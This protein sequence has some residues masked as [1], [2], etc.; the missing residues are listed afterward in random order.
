MKTTLALLLTA[1]VSTSVLAAPS[2]DLTVR[3]DDGSSTIVV[4]PGETINFEIHG[5]LSS[6]TDNEGLAL[7]GLDLTN[8]GGPLDGS[9]VINPTADPIMQNF[10]RN[11]GITNPDSPCPPACGFSGT[12]INDDLVQVGGGQNTINNTAANAPFPIGGVI[13]NVAHP[14][15]GQILAEGTITAPAGVGVYTLSIPVSSVF[16]N[17]ISPGQGCAPNPA[18]PTT[19][20]SAEAATVG[21]IINL[22]Y[23]VEDPVCT[24]AS[25]TVWES[26]GTHLRGVGDVALAITAPN[27]DGTSSF[28]EPRGSGLS[29]IRVS[30]TPGTTIDAGSAVAGNVAV[31]G[32]DVGGNPVDL[33][34]VV[35]GVSSVAS[36]TQLEITFTPALPDFATY[37]VALPGITTCGGAISG[38]VSGCATALQ[39]DLSG[40]VRVRAN[41]VAGARGYVGIDPIDPV[42][43]I[44]QA[45]SDISLDG[46]IRA[47]DVSAIISAVG[48]DA[49][50]IVCPAVP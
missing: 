28:S 24:P 38:V 47:N 35:V 5:M 46:R 11:L 1:V 4:A 32:T 14:P 40:D 44:F 8:S 22:Q 42:A 12:M 31:A 48:H 7:F 33:T 15:L 9:V 39:G 41:D 3:R 36:D 30:F 27:L 49:R 6:D 19:F 25:A 43:D 10:T 37:T 16:A 21:T 17:V 18:D 23:T 26:V 50:A 29:R 34:G 20:C 2:L 45:R 13:V